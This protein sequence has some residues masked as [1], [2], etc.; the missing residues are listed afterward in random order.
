M[1]PA[2]QKFIEDRANDAWSATNI[3]R[4]LQKSGPPD[5]PTLRTVQ[6]LVRDV[7]RRDKSGPWSVADK[8]KD[9]NFLYTPEDTR[10]ILDVLADITLHTIWDLVRSYMKAESK[11]ESTEALDGYLAFQPWKSENRRQDYRTAL[12]R[13]LM[14]ED[15][16]GW[17]VWTETWYQEPSD[18]NTERP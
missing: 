13:G 15:P 6:N 11:G 12:E 14:K 5:L 3:Y 4:E 2:L 16:D 7:V 17:W 8:G 18:F 10:I 1:D 9:G